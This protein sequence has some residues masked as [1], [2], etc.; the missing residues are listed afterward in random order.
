MLVAGALVAATSLAGT[1]VGSAHT[2]RGAGGSSSAF[3]TTAQRLQSEIQD[4]RNLDIETLS[5]RS[6]RSTARRFGNLVK[7]L[8]KQAPTE[9]TDEFRRL[10]RLYQRVVDG[11]LTLSKLPDA[12][13]KA[14]DDLS[15]IFTYLRDT[16]G[17]TFESPSTTA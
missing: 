13:S 8:Q 15:T 1:G 2:V 12:I 11:K 9:L 14:A 16:C 4:L 5:A 3:C 10:R 17:I 7:Q 6:V